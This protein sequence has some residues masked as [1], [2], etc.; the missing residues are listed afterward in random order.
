M[1]C[2]YLFNTSWL[3][4]DFAGFMFNRLPVETAVNVQQLGRRSSVSK[5]M[6]RVG[7]GVASQTSVAQN[8]STASSLVVC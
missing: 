2:S 6:W 4:V 8:R 7:G 5:S 3:A 1:A